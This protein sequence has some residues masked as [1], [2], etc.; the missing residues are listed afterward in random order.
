MAEIPD[1]PSLTSQ[2]HTAIR[3]R[4]YDFLF[5]DLFSLR[6]VIPPPGKNGKMLYCTHSRWYVIPHSSNRCRLST[7]ML[8][9]TIFCNSSTLM[10]YWTA[11]PTC[12]VTQPA[13]P[14]VFSHTRPSPSDSTSLLNTRSARPAS[15]SFT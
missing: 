11:Q 7:L 15:L 13:C 6:M 8:T 5:H 14:M 4:F 10:E 3:S 1:I 9:S 12:P 2:V